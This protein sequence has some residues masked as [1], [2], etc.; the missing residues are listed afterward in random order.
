VDL[1]AAVEES[2]EL[3]RAG[4]DV[5]AGSHAETIRREHLRRERLFGWVGLLNY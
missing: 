3:G 1:E 4:T 5:P 2:G